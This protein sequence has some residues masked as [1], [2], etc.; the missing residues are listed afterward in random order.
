LRKFILGFLLLATIGA[1][2]AAYAG[3]KIYGVNTSHDE[4]KVLFIPTGSSCEDVVGSL[5]EANILGD[6]S[7]FSWVAGLMNYKNKVKSGR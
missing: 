5:K 1:L 4:E 7:S 3:Y 2:V 6:E